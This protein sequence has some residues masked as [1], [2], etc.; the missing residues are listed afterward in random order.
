VAIRGAEMKVNAGSVRQVDTAE[1]R[2]IQA[3]S[4]LSPIHYRE[5]FAVPVDGDRSAEQWARLLL[6]GASPQKRA[7]MQSAW[8]LLGLDLIPSDAADQILGWRIRSDGDAVVLAT[9]S[10]TGLTAR[11]VLTAPAGQVVYT[12]VVR[13]DRWFSRFLWFAIASRHRAFVRG[14]LQDLALRARP[15]QSRPDRSAPGTR[16]ASRASA[17]DPPPPGPSAGHAGRQSSGNERTA[18]GDPS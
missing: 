12:M 9:R 7:A 14:L 8:R 5:A 1:A 2:E 18:P 3:R 13:Y 10:S 16:S 11:I 4:G 15:Q 6:E 17:E